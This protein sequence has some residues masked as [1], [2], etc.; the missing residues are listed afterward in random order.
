V[1]DAAKFLDL[2]A[3]GEPVTFQTFDDSKA[4][5]KNLAKVMHGEL[6]SNEKR[7]ES[8]NDKGAGVFVTVNATDQQGRKRENIKRVRAVFVDLD[9]APIGP[10]LTGPLMPHLTV[11]SSPDRYHA[12]WLTDDIALEEFRP[13]QEALARRFDGDTTVKDLPRVMRLPGYLHRKGEPFLTSIRDTS[14]QDRYSRAD[15]LDAFGIDPSVNSW[16]GSED[17]VEGKRND[18]LFRMARGFMGKGIAKSGIV[19]RL[20]VINEKRCKPPLTDT[21][22]LQIVEQASQYGIDGAVTI[23]YKEFDSPQYRALS[24]MARDLRQITRRVANS[25]DQTPFSLLPRDL[26]QWGYGN[27]KTLAKYRD[28]LL[29]SGW[30]VLHRAPRFGEQGKTRECG[31]YRIATPDFYGKKCH[32]TR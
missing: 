22:I 23:E 24:P 28:E 10:V 15:I 29:E 30:L 20:S 21:E 8:L 4:K 17:I 31:L 13:I 7:L 32:K 12:Y 1:S 19:Q 14:E 25:N 18:T 26:G 27:A 16:K 3:E 2:L 9:G 6:A 5:R 11:V